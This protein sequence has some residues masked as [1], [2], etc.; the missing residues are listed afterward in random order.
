MII[1]DTDERIMARIAE[2]YPRVPVILSWTRKHIPQIKRQIAPYQGAVLAALA[3]HYDRDGARF[4]EIGTALG[5]SA[6]LMATAAPKA[7]ITTLNPK[8]GEYERAVGNLHI[9]KNVEVKKLTSEEYLAQCKEAFDLVFVDG[10]HSRGMVTHDAGFFNHLK[11]GGL[12]LFHDYAPLDSTRPGE[13][14]YQ[15]LNALKKK[16][17]KFDVLVVGDGKVGIAGW[18]R[19]E[20]EVW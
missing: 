6:C 14:V 10:D 4:L 9:R 16:Q 7:R 11:V 8:K 17:R 13:G 2:D 15:A 20:G 5:Y 3:S 18:Y 1:R 19:Q 12:I